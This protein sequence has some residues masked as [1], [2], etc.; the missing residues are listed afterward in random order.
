MNKRYLRQHFLLLLFVQLVAVSS[1]LATDG[2]LSCI[3]NNNTSKQKTLVVLYKTGCPFCEQMNKVV[4]SDQ[5]LQQQLTSNFRVYTLDINSSEGQKLAQQFDIHAVPTIISFINE[6]GEHNIIRGFGN[7]QRFAERI[8][9][10]IA[11]KKEVLTVNEKAGGSLASVCG[12][13][14]VEGTES[15]D[16]GNNLGGDGCSASCTIQAGYQCTGSPSVCVPL[17]VCGDG[18]VQ[19]GEQC[20]DGNNVTGDGC[21]AACNVQAG[22]QC[23]GT[24]SVCT[25]L[26]V[27]GDGIVQI[28]EQ[29][30]DGNLANGDGCSATC[31]LENGTGGILIKSSAGVADYSAML[32]ISSTQR[33]VLIP[34][35]SS[36]QRTDIS[37]AATGLMVFDATTGSFWYYGGSAWKE[38]KSDGSN[39]AFS[40]SIPAIAQSTVPGTTI[41]VNFAAEDFD[42]GGNNFLPP[43]GTYTVP[44]S[45]VYEFSATVGININSSPAA[46]T[47]YTMYVFESAGFTTRT[48]GT[49]TLVV[50]ANY[51]GNIN[52]SATGTVKL[53]AGTGGIVRVTLAASPNSSPQPLVTGKFSGH[54]VY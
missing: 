21:D 51:I 39:T 35:L 44:A 36:Q 26:A 15:C 24:P 32:D 27:C 28:G 10:A 48:I 3:V 22:Y 9:I 7:K 42:E 33:G 5:P 29:C 31:K 43:N 14:V 13:G 23:T 17:A 6:T 20:D 19:A 16:D 2:F 1:L 50:A 53:T 12:D 52:L 46:N 8:G 45:G 18:I 49:T 4:S 11:I 25:S 34:R 47:S 30:D 40:G 41:N 37:A 54:R 38:I